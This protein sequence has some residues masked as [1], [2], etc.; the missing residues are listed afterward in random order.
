MKQ[1]IFK[2]LGPNGKIITDIIPELELI[3]GKQPE[4]PKLGPNETRNRF[5]I[6]IERFVSVFT[7]KEHPIVLFLDDL[8]WAD[9]ASLQLIRYLITSPIIKHLLIIGSYRDN[10]VSEFHSLIKILKEIGEAGIRINRIVLSEL[11]VDDVKDLAVNFLRCSEKSGYSLGEVIHKK[12]GGNPFFINEFLHT[13]YDEKLIELDAHLGWKWDID[14]I[15]RVS[16]TD[17]MVKFLSDKISAPFRLFFGFFQ[18]NCCFKS[19]EFL[20]LDISVNA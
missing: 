17:N 4:V 1:N 10:E 15:K 8:Q 14:R 16:I 7:Q 20:I 11:T 18:Y 9:L 12:T 6:V 5:N 19:S 2:A 3:I 13:L